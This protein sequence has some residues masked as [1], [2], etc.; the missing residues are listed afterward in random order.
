MSRRKRKEYPPGTFLP[1]SQRLLAILQL[2]IAF[3]LILW[4]AAQPFM[5][6][7]FNLRSR[8]MIYE[9]AMGTSDILKKKGEDAKLQRNAERFEDLSASQKATLLSDYKK[10]QDHAQ[11]PVY[12][13]IL[14]GFKVL[15]LDIPAFEMA[16]IFF[17][18][19]IAI[20]LLLKV[21]GSKQAVWLLPLLV[22]GYSIDNR[23]EGI[24]KRFSPDQKL[25]PSEQII[26][27]NYLKEPLGLSPTEQQNQLQRGWEDYLIDQWLPNKDLSGSRNDKVEKAE[28]Q[29][30]FARLHLLHGQPQAEWFPSFRERVSSPL[31]FLFMSWNL[32]LAWMMNRKLTLSSDKLK[33]N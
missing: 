22:L 8:M 27:Q 26:V 13:K 14:D 7:Y 9:Y 15:F 23:L 21:E 33:I 19:V 1:T 4:Y 2:F 28:F 32:L 10:L 11:R 24:P 18:I 25:F 30:T 20:L 12:V 6:E 29:F 5:G 16:W 17:S 3:S 31:L